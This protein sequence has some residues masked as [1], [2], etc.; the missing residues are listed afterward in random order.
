MIDTTAP[1]VSISITE[2]TNNDGLLSS[3]ELDGQV[4]YVVTLAAGTALGDTLVI[5]D[6]D[7]NELFNGPVTQAMLDSGLALAVN[8]PADGATLTLTATVTDPAG[9]SYSAHDSVTIDTT[10]PN[11][12]TVLIVDD[13]IPGDGVLTQSEI[14]NNGAGVQIEVNI[15]ATDFLA[16]GHVNLTINNSAVITSIELKIVDVGNGVIELQF[17]DGTPATNFSYSN[18][19][20]SWT[21][22]TPEAGQDIT[23]Y[24]TQ[25]DA[26][27]N[28]SSQGSDTATVNSVPTIN[29]L[30]NVIVSEEGLPLGLPD[31]TGDTDSTNSPDASGTVSIQDSNNDNLTV[32]LSGPSG[33][34]SG[35][36]AIQWS[37]D[38]VT[39]TLTG[40]IGT[41]GEASYTEIMTATLTPPVNGSSGNWT[42]DVT[43]KGPVDH[44]DTET[45]DTLSVNIGINVDDGHGGTS[46]GSFNVTIEDDAPV[47]SPIAAVQTTTTSIPDSLV[48]SFSLTGYSGNSN[49]LDFNGFTIS[50]RGFTSSTNSNLIDAAIFGSSSGIGVSSAGAPYHN[51]ANEVDFRK[52][53]DGSSASEEIIITLDPGTIAYGVNIQFSHMFGGE[54]EVGVVEFWRDGQ[55][56]ATQTFSSDASSGDYAANFQALQGGFDT[57]V[58][59]AL[60]NGQGPNSGDNSDFTVTAIEFLGTTT[61]PA[62]AFASGTV[63]PDWGADGKGSLTLQGSDETNL[64]T[65]TG[66]AIT[67][68]QTAN[69]LIGVDAAG[70]LVFKLEFT[71]GT[72]QWDFHQYQKM[73]QPSDGDIDFKVRATDGDGDHFDATFSVI[74]QVNITPS[75]SASTVTGLEDTAIYFDW[76]K[77]NVTDSDTAKAELSIKIDSLPNPLNGRLQYFENGN[78]LNVT[79][80][81]LITSIM[82]DAGHLRFIPTQNEADGLL[83]GTGNQGS[84]LASFTYSVTDGSS[85]SAPTTMD[86]KIEAVADAPNLTASI[87]KVVWHDVITDNTLNSSHT[88]GSNDFGITIEAVK[89]GRTATADSDDNHYLQGISNDSNDLTGKGGD[90][91]LVG[92]DLNDNLTGGAGDDVFVGGGLNDSIYGGAGIDTAVYS[93]NRSEYVITWHSDH[94]SLPYML[95]NDRR[96]IDS[97]SVNTNDLDAG[98][99]LYEVERLVFA[100]GVFIINPDGSLTQVQTTEIKLNIN[101]SLVD[102]DGSETLSAI[103]I[104]GVPTGAYLS[105]GTLNSDGSWTLTQAQL[106]N[107]SMHVEAN[108]S[109]NPD[110]NLHITVS[111]EEQSNG[112]TATSEFDLSVSLRGYSYINGTHGDNTIA[113]TDNND[114][115]V[116]DVQGIQIIEGESYNIAFIFDTSGSMYGKITEAKAQL[117]TVFEQLVDA[118]SGAQSGVVNLMLTDF[119][120]NSN[121]TISVNLQDPNAL[122]TLINQLSSIVDDNSGNTNYEAGFES[123]INWFNSANIA[124]NGGTNLSYFITDGQPNRDSDDTN[125]S[126]FLV[127][128]DQTTGHFVDLAQLITQQNYARG[129]T[130][131]FNG[132]VIADGSGNVYSFFNGEQVGKIT[133]N[134]NGSVKNFSDSNI[135]TNIQTKLAF[136]L[137]SAVSTVEAIGL[138]SGINANQLALYDTDGVVRANIDVNT[139]ASVILGTSVQLLQGDD[140]INGGQGGDIIFGDLTQFQGINSQG[141]SALQQY[142]SQQLNDGTETTV[143]EV[144]QYI[145]D[146]LS[147][148]DVSRNND[149]DDKLNGGIGDDILFGQG[150]DDILNGESGNDILIGGAGNDILS[151]GTGNDT[152]S[153]GFGNDILSGGEGNDTLIGGLG[154]DTLSGDSGADTFVWRYA[155]SGTDH[156]TDFNVNEDKLDLSDLLQGENSS[157]L[158][159][160]LNFTLVGGSTVIDIDANHDGNFEQHI[161]LD[162]VDL[163]SAYNTT[164]ETGIINGLLGS[165]G[166]GPLIIDNAPITPEVSP[167]TLHE[168]KQNDGSIIP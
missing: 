67:I 5:V 150:G 157:N 10:A 65:A 98:D 24:A 109:G 32:S 161:V 13:G 27:G 16:G 17:A 120:S 168:T 70:H 133:F 102:T 145:T 55:L 28:T 153:G 41:A 20:I 149:G 21:E 90:D 93:G 141:Y 8:V 115:I 75:V 15:D 48:G 104:T 128:Y 106:A 11:P 30:N 52:F 33:L 58:I 148:F 79:T 140:T 39:Q 160:Y 92:G 23:I 82:I 135:S 81:M 34:F 84:P 88:V 44:P 12:P 101:A 83:G 105:A 73:L 124:N 53:A 122:T 43:L 71:P 107:L 63:N 164:T 38:P 76:S 132:K 45:E 163:Y 77:F 56:I 136:D 116:S 86:V 89:S 51:L 152:L 158:D 151:G 95:I 85:N 117:T 19:I 1:A 36:Q 118:A 60:D 64:F 68:T 9:N 22:S 42:Y 142:V 125:T 35:G 3:A 146:H 59:K 49:S 166:N 74:P 87:S 154:N 37:W 159:S 29:V 14:S 110:V 147:E 99:H 62:I 94:G 103:T 4:N 156:I 80:G 69:T 165:N 112:S 61:P 31:S 113:G 26:A 167:L 127:A 126:K 100:D 131:T 40:Y 134:S 114:V 50:A 155:E 130:I 111:S 47:I 129:N 162:G 91:I 66:S 143:A 139:L 7:G 137:L 6:Q 121:F 138:G 97:S 119:A 54:L 57:M 108:Y 72:G 2:D 46:T 96:G 123:A 144:H 78:W 18:G 25:T